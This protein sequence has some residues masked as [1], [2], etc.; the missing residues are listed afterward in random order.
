MSRPAFRV[1][2]PANPIQSIRL[3]HALLETPFDVR[4]P[5]GYARKFRR[6][7]DVFGLELREAN[8]AVPILSDVSV[9]HNAGGAP[10]S[11]VGRIERPLIFAHGVA[12]YLEMLWPDIRDLHVSFV[13]RLHETRRTVI[14]EWI[15]RQ[16]PD[17]DLSMPDQSVVDRRVARRKQLQVWG[18]YWLRGP[19][20]RLK[21]WIE[22]PAVEEA[23]HRDGVLL[24]TSDRGW[25]FPTKAWDDVYY[26]TL[27]NSSFVLCPNGRFVWTYRF[28]EATLCG[29]IPIVQTTCELYEGFR[30]FTMDDDVEQMIW[31]E[32]DALHNAALC[33][34]RLTVPR[35]EL[36][37]EI[38]YLLRVD[39]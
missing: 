6:L 19:L 18:E 36:N 7:H 22:L 34:E 25:G 3:I 39:V 16:F 21:P 13:G 1:D 37:D 27:A 12:D 32:A 11:R 33:R 14:E 31:N 38:R 2:L 29:A 17:L 35:G 9:I 10:I 28:F 4:I 30:Y 15:T 24:M 8:A 26:Q 20:H 23:V 5:P